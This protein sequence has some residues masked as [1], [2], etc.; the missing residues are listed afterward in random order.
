MFTN[1]RHVPELAQ[2]LDAWAQ[3][4]STDRRTFRAAELPSPMVL[5]KPGRACESLR[6]FQVC[7]SFRGSSSFSSR[8]KLS[9]PFELLCNR[10]NNDAQDF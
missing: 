8:S 4:S 10:A 9:G 5:F 6:A 3:A 2:A 1:Y 7:S